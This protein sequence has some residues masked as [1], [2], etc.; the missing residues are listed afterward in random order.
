MAQA[1]RRANITDNVVV[2]AKAKVPIIKFVTIE[3]EPA[4][5]Y[6][7]C[8]VQYCIFPGPPRFKRRNAEYAR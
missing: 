8:L 5:L 7:C 6:S 3:G 4:L 1:V 2:I